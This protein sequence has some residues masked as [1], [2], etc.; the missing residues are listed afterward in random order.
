M[1]TL[2]YFLKGI[3]FSNNVFENNYFMESETLL[4]IN[5]Y[6]TF[7]FSSFSF[8]LFSSVFCRMQIQWQFEENRKNCICSEDCYGNVKWEAGNGPSNYVY[9]K[10]IIHFAFCMGLNKQWAYMEAV[11]DGPKSSLS[12]QFHSMENG[13]RMGNGEPQ[14]RFIFSPESHLLLNWPLENPT[15]P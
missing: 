3:I 13:S 4:S 11:V 7:W 12:S 6:K 8:S 1:R 5:T 2:L 14:Q 15:Q 9:I 10:M